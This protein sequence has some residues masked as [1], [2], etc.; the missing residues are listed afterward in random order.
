MNGWLEPKYMDWLWHGFAVTLEL[1]ACAAVSATL[2]G[3]V[4]ALARSARAAWPRRIAA[5]YV[6]VFRAA[7][8][9]RWRGSMLRTPSRSARSS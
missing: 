8:M 4:L 5:L 9:R 1:A 7:P 6:L 2:L 3:F